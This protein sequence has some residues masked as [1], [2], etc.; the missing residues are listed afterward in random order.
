[1]AY[2][3]HDSFFQLGNSLQREDSSSSYERPCVLFVFMLC[4]AVTLALGG[5]TGWHCKLI[6]YGETSI[7]WHINKQDARKLQKQGL[8]SIVW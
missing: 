8:V 7:E 3:I 6:S 4:S 2:F 5:L 1:M